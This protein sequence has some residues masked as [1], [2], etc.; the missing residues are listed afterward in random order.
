MS[1]YYVQNTSQG[2]PASM[3][4]SDWSGNDGGVIET[5]NPQEAPLIPEPPTRLATNSDPNATPLVREHFRSARDNAISNTYLMNSRGNNSNISDNNG[6][7]K[8][9]SK[10]W[11][12][13]L[14]VCLVLVVIIGGCMYAIRSDHGSSIANPAMSGQSSF[15]SGGLTQNLSSGLLN[16]LEFL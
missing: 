13:I 14:L 9:D 6:N 10:N 4:Y 5:L 15:G 1:N 3:H 11:M 16:D 12:G 2:Q 7:E 8:C